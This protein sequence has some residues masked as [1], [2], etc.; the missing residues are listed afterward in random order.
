VD[1]QR[2]EDE[3]MKNTRKSES[4]VLSY[5]EYKHL[6]IQQCPEIAFVNPSSKSFLMMSH[7]NIGNPVGFCVYAFKKSKEYRKIQYKNRKKLARAGG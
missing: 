5:E 4:G 6:A 2:Q 3:S 1:W 7:W